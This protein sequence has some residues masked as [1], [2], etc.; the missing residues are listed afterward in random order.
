MS[1]ANPDRILKFV[2][3]WR[4][5]IVDASK[6]NPERLSKE[7]FGTL[8]ALNTIIYYIEKMQ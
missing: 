8:V 3:D 7:D 1:L 4:Q 6:G 2:T 5:K